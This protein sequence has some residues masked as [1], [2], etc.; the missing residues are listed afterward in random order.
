MYES[1]IIVIQYDYAEQA[2]VQILHQD[3]TEGKQHERRREEELIVYCIVTNLYC[4]I[5]L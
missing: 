4:Q 3:A 5:F 2:Q 1:Y